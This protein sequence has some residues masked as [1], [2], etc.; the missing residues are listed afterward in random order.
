MTT[1]LKRELSTQEQAIL[2]GKKSL[3]EGMSERIERMHEAVRRHG[4]PALQLGRALLF[5]ESFKETE[6]K[7]L[8]L[9]WATA[10]KHIAENI[11]VTIL[12]G[13]LIVGRP[14]N[15]FGTCVIAFPEL[16]GS[17]L[18][19]AIEA[20]DQLKGK[21]GYVHFSDES[22]KAIREVLVPYWKDR[23][24]VTAYVKSLPEETR[25]V[26]FGPD[27]N[28]IDHQMGVLQ[29]SAA[30]RS[31]SNFVPDYEKILKLGCKGIRDDVKTRLEEITNPNDYAKKVSFLEAVL[32]VCDAMVIY[33]NRYARLAKD[34]A[35]KE[36]DA[37]RK[38]ELEEIAAVCESVPENPARTF[39]ESLQV[40]WFV[41]L[42]TKMEQSLGSGTQSGR[43]DQYLFP[44]FE[45]DVKDGRLTKEAA[46][47]LLQC[48]WINMEQ[49]LPTFLSRT[50]A[51]STE[52]F[53][54]FELVVVGG[55]TREG[56][57]AT[58]D[59]SYA[60]LE[61]GRPMQ[62]SYPEFAV[63]VHAN[64]PDKLLHLAVEAVKDGKG[65]PKFLNDE[66]IIPFYNDMGV[67]M[68]ECMNYAPSSCADTRIVNVEDGISG[69]DMINI[70]AVLEL[71]LRDGKI[72]ALK[73]LQLGLNTGDPRNFQTYED[74][75]AAFRKQLYHLLKHQMIQQR[76]A[77]MAEPRYLACPV[78]SML[79]SPSIEAGMDMHQQEEDIPGTIC[80]N[81]LESV[82]KSTVID[83]FAAIKHLIY[84]TK[85]LSW[86]QLL[87]ALEKNWDGDEAI[88]QMCLNAPKHGNGIEWVDAIGWELENLF[89]EYSYEN[90][91]ANGQHW[92][93]RAVPVTAHVPLGKIVSAT[94]NGRHVH[95]FLSEGVSASH[96]ADTKG[97]TVAFGSISRARASN[98]GGLNG[99]GLMNMK[100]APGNV[101]GEQGTRR[102]MQMIRAWCNLKLWHVQFN[103]LNK[104]TLI[105]AQKDPEKYRD[106]VV[107]I[108]GYSAYF[109]DLTPMQQAEI[110]ARTEQN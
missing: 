25:F 96:G 40:Q 102:L 69:G 42:W 22:K 72:K 35:A 93:L 68:S 83:S 26:H 18:L 99:P 60:I 58:N 59:L 46:I 84:D 10:L 63:R 55:L 97:P 33:A 23:D 27:P 62:S 3:Q 56:L 20:F 4:A 92:P 39:R 9:R 79:F 106:L 47:E 37:T 71:T 1:A 85:K 104:E 44:Y 54:H 48:V 49:L 5:T 86:D 80:L 31:S 76:F 34:L 108:A 17:G 66:A 75:W 87:N 65:T 77:G 12:P 91:K 52:G 14:H 24:Y 81:Y 2:E 11:E 105:A 8:V 53:A 30:L 78:A 38:K 6:G 19:G 70:P 98:W 67:P 100:F 28:N 13:E 73:D 45:K 82:G 61:S 16:D 90:P 103:I 64:T 21:T 32:L 109:V 50:A 88:R 107:R 95:E 94:P 43:M 74:L 15:F 57:D 51:A 36:A 101:A 29:A 110:I 41:Q 7:P 89:C